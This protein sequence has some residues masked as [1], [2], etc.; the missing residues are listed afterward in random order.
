M[1][2][3]RYCESDLEAL[4]DVW[5]RSV[6]A[7][8][9]FLSEEDVAFFLPLVRLEPW[10]QMETWILES[11]DRKMAGFMSLEGD[12]MEALFI[13]PEYLHQGLARIMHEI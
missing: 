7:T 9:H 12:K 5:L 11:D 10:C 4:T 8:H 1:K 2:I 3:Q 13:A 6:K